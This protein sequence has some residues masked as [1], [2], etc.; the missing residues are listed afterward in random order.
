[1]GLADNGSMTKASTAA[2]ITHQYIA[3][4]DKPVALLTPGKLGSTTLYAVHTDHRNAP[5]ALTDEQRQVVW[6]AKVS[7]YGYASQVDRDQANRDQAT[8]GTV[9]YN[10]RASNQ[11]FDAETNLH[12]NTHRYF[13][14]LAQRYLTPDP[15]GLAVGPDLYAF[16]LNRPHELS[17]PLGLAPTGP[18]SGWTLDDKLVEIIKRA[19]PQMPGEVGAALSELTQPENLAKMAIITAVFIGM[20]AAGP[21]AWIADAALLGSAV[22]MFGS[23]FFDLATAIIGLYNNAKAAKCE[24]D[25]DSAATQLS[26]GLV[27]SAGGILL[28]GVGM[29]NAARIGQGVRTLINYA[30]NLAKPPLAATATTVVKG[31]TGATTTLGALLNNLGGYIK[32]ADMPG[33][34]WGMGP[35]YTKFQGDPWEVMVQSLLP[36]GAVRFLNTKFKGFDHYIQLAAN[37]FRMI[38]SKTLDTSLPS[39]QTA[40]NIAGKI[41]GFVDDT[42]KFVTDTDS[43][44]PITINAAEIVSREVQLLIPSTTNAAQWVVIQQEIAAAAARGVKVIVSIGTP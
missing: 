35:N 30:K 12:Y 33:F 16:A 42:L 39:Y 43:K 41:R 17:D 22:W 11:Y 19:I 14:P 23:G 32:Q 29:G 6:Q 27:K 8:L 28:G 18:V 38:S 20:Q 21:L 13:D 44:I 24:G 15:L 9:T 3:L 31:T 5:L 34:K 2:A 10:L 37:K 40:S 1:M 4:D 7:D 36:K 26:N 25:L